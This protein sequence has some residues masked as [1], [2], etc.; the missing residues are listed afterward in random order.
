[1]SSNV[2]GKTTSK[3]RD[4]KDLGDLAPVPSAPG[5]VID[6]GEVEEGDAVFGLVQG[7]GPNYRNVRSNHVK[8]RLMHIS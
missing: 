5:E 7:G 3:T 2:L 4:D 1:M 8:A 6:G